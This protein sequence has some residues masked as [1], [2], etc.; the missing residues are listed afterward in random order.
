MKLT[1]DILYQ[2]TDSRSFSRGE[3]YFANGQVDGLKEYQGTI[4][5]KV[6]G[7]DDYRVKLWEKGGKIGYSCDCPIGIEG[8]FC[9]HCVAVG[10]AWI[11]SNENLESTKGSVVD[12]GDIGKWLDSQD[13]ST[14]VEMLMQ[15]V[16]EDDRLH[17]KLLIKAATHNAQALDLAVYRQ[18]IDAAVDSRGFIEY[19]EVPEYAA[20]ISTAIEGIEDILDGGYASAAIELLEYAIEVVE[21]ALCSVDDSCGYI[22]GILNDLQDL[23]H[24]ACMQGKPDPES[25][26]KRLFE[27]EMGTDYDTFYGAVDQYADVLGKKGLETYNK[28]AVEEWAKVPKR[29]PGQDRDNYGRPFRITNIMERLADQTRDIEAL[30][31]IKKHD[32]SSPWKYLKIAEIYQKEGQHDNALDWAE[33]GLKEFPQRPDSRVRDFLAEEYHRRNRHDEA[34]EQIWVQFV[35]SPSFH[36]YQTLKD[37]ADRIEQW[38]SWREKALEHIRS[39]IHKDKKQSQGYQWA[40]EA[41]HSLLVKIFLWEG[42]INKSWLEAQEGGCSRDLWLELAEKREKAHPM[43]ALAIYKDEIEP[44]LDQKCNEAYHRATEFLKKI[45]NLML[46][47]DQESDF[48]QYLSSV[49]TVHKPKRNFM[50]ILNSTTW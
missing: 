24:K 40:R 5:A 38:Q 19:R 10:L 22:G 27:W 13:K 39:K 25:L 28:L 8:A 35:D 11:S 30:V 9:K 45:R 34:M 43:D 37:H 15:Q 42:D 16:L 3:A 4:T 44:T 50:K 47:L 7:T 46:K 12:M 2:K 21:E 29:S 18:A 31:A 33:R 26:A 23:H 41:D 1:K 14:L 17:Q 49:K 6:Y 48:H 36:S 20:G 32:L